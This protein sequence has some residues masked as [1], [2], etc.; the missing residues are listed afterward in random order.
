[1]ASKMTKIIWNMTLSNTLNDWMNEGISDW[2]NSWNAHTRM[3]VRQLARTPACSFSPITKSD[4]YVK[5]LKLSAICLIIWRC[6]KIFR[7]NLV[8]KKKQTRALVEKTR[9]C[10]VISVE[11]ATATASCCEHTHFKNT[12][13]Y[14]YIANAPQTDDDDDD[15]NDS[16]QHFDNDSV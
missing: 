15:D 2:E 13:T 12:N 10:Q 14:G 8:S 9:K 11:A 7:E 5:L 6:L 16:Q 3:S 1:M 4:N